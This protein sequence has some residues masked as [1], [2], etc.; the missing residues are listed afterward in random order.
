[1]RP[2]IDVTTRKDCDKNQILKK[3]NHK[4]NLLPTF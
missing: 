3:N 1:M 2:V 4:Q